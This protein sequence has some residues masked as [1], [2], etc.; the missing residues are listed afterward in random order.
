[1]IWRDEARLW[2]VLDNGNLSLLTDKN[3][4]PSTWFDSAEGWWNGYEDFNCIETRTAWNGSNGII[5]ITLNQT[6]S[7]HHWCIGTFMT[8]LKRFPDTLHT[9]SIMSHRIKRL[10][11]PRWICGTQRHYLSNDTYTQCN[12]ASIFPVEL[13]LLS[14]FFS[15]PDF[16]TLSIVLWEIHR[17]NQYKDKRSDLPTGKFTH[18]FSITIDH[19]KRFSCPL[20][21]QVPILPGWH[22]L[23]F[24][25]RLFRSH[26][27]VQVVKKTRP[28]PGQ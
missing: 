18:Y 27:L 21:R 17:I 9:S 12:N 2:A 22:L 15:L 19:K 24:M 25:F 26:S 20:H 23:K 7:S 6:L 11:G 5:V 8:H 14:S 1:M 3:T 13:S 16:S 10:K 28:Q 4:I